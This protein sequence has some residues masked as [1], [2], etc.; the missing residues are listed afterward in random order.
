M[1]IWYI[2]IIW[3]VIFIPVGI[4]ILF[5][6]GAAAIIYGSKVVFALLIALIVN[7]Q[8]PLF[9]NGF[10]SYLAWAAMI[11]MG[12]LILSIWMPRFNCAYYF[13]A[14]AVVSFFL[15][16]FI[17]DTLLP[18]ILGFFKVEFEYTLWMDIVSR[19]ACLAAGVYAAYRQFEDIDV[20]GFSASL[21]GRTIDRTMASLVYG[22]G[23]AILTNTSIE[24]A[25]SLP[26]YL[27]GI[28]IGVV[29][30]GYFIFDRMVIGTSTYGGYSYRTTSTSSFD[31]DDGECKPSV[32]S[33]LLTGN[34]F[35][36]SEKEIDE[37]ID[38][39]L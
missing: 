11:G 29:A 7:S 15:T 22:F 1:W 31:Y 25:L 17:L 36:L 16:F 21:I 30:V 14:T 13:I 23:T 8:H 5:I 4:A 26:E 33:R 38:N 34:L 27:V 19:I 37:M 3:A 2:L 9:E 6:K 32:E 35:G 28:V 39:Q 12:L 10:L 18:A 24:N 20:S